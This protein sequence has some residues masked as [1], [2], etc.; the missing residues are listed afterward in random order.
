[1]SAPGVAV[2]LEA[3]ARA[4]I[5][6]T[7]TAIAPIALERIFKRFGPMP[8]VIGT[9]EQTGDWDHA[10]ATR[11][12]ELGDG[13]EAHERISAYAAPQH[14]AY[15][16]RGFTGPLRLLVE[17]ADG[18]WWFSPA[19]GGA[20][21][22]RWTYVFQPRPVRGWLTLMVVAPLWR[23]YARRALERAVMVAEAA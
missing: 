23:A 1:M 8:P 3:E 20:T 10:G 21:Q 13:S 7:F 16:V 14:F 2:T 12:V 19:A 17:H 18:A 6:Q 15:R 22:I 9:R 5:E 11:V 4:G